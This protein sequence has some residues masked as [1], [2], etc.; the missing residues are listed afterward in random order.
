MEELPLLEPEKML[1]ELMIKMIEDND[2]KER[3][4]NG[5]ERS[6]NFNIDNIIKK[7]EIM[8]RV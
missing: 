4:A 3:Y 8:L 6:D 2:L 7:W 5:S 1:S